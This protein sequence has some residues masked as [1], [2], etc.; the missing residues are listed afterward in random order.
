MASGP[1]VKTVA[2]AAGVS[3]ASVSNAYNKPERLSPQVRERILATAQAQGY[4]GPDAA[5]RS[6]RTGRA[7]MIGVIFTVQLSY[8]FTDPYCSAM[9]TGLS[10]IAERTGTGLVLLPFTPP[11][12]GRD[13][14]AVRESVKAVHRAVI[15]G[16]VADGLGDDHP[17]VVALATR[18]VPLVRSVDSATGRCVLINDEAAG[19]SIGRHLARLGHRDVTVILASPFEPGQARTDL[20][21]S[22]LYAYS[23]M[24]LEG[25]RDGLGVDARVRVVSGG[26]NATESGRAAA[27]HIF[28]GGDRPSA[29]AADSDLLALGVLDV[30]RREGLEP[31]RDISVTG[32]DDLPAAAAAG[33]TTVRQP[34]Q[35]KG[36]LMGRMLLDPAFTERRIVLPTE[37]VVRSTTGAIH[38]DR[39]EEPDADR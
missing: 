11:T 5:A 20:D 18:G 6:L 34:I 8:A 3:P 30:V 9:L 35:E 15:D 10:E 33:L 28:D 25:I 32:F 17:A 16:A 26:R 31:G 1:N 36:R 27:A 2:E 22:V 37:L 7:G 21:E 4:A 12:G 24:R 39:T 38:H 14:N 29:I 13:A 19:C 23:R